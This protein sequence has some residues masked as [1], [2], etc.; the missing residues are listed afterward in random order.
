MILIKITTAVFDAFVYV[1][2]NVFLFAVAFP[3]NISNF[4]C[5]KARAHWLSEY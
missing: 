1:A 4:V 2:A 3:F 5:Y